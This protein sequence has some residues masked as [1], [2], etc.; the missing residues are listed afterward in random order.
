MVDGQVG[1][2]RPENIRRIKV[3]K[4]NDRVKRLNKTKVERQ[5]TV[6]SL[7]K[8]QQDRLA[9]IQR[10]KK[11]YYK[12]QQKIKQEQALLAQQEKELRSYD[13]L[14]QNPNNMTA[15]SEQEATADATAA[16]AYE[17]DFF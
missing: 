1:F 17:D 9:E 10:Q 16:E 11:Q 4:H 13:R 14:F 7:Y 6:E 5:D 8:A 15:V 12:Q 2:H 3:E